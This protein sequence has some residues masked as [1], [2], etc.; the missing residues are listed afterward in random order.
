MN[1]HKTYYFKLYHSLPAFLKLELLN[2]TTLSKQPFQDSRSRLSQGLRSSFLSLCA[3]AKKMMAEQIWQYMLHYFVEFGRRNYINLCSLPNI[4][5]NYVN[6]R[7]SSL[8]LWYFTA[9]CLV[10]RL[11]SI[12]NMYSFHNHTDGNRTES[13]YKCDLTHDCASWTSDRRGIP[14]DHLSSSSAFFPCF[15]Y[16][17][18]WPSSR[19]TING[20]S[21]I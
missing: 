9:Y 8:N 6:L 14:L 13:G 11:I 1:G 19:I 16:R 7:T 18:R 21:R 10:C 5:T 15:N 17:T 4:R 20:V 3:R 12:S 2:I